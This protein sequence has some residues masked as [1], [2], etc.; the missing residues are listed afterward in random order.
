M[1][2]YMYSGLPF[3]SGF[4]G[5]GAGP[6]PSQPGR[7][8]P[9]ALRLRSDHKLSASGG[10]SALKCTTTCLCSRMKQRDELFYNAEHEAVPTSGFARNAASW[11]LAARSGRPCWRRWMRLPTGGQRGS[12]SAVR[13]SARKEPG[14]RG[15]EALAPSLAATDL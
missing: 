2:K 8:C 11:S 3:W 15:H 6:G 14:Q 13:L 4:G 5:L 10:S 9:R 1:R 12:A 7:D